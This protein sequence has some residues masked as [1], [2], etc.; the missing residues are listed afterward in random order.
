MKQEER[1]LLEDRLDVC[2]DRRRRREERNGTNYVFGQDDRR[3]VGC[4]CTERLTRPT[5]AFVMLV[6]W[7]ML[8]YR[9]WGQK[10]GMSVA[11]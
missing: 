9:R 11:G 6:T 7:D 1:R 5:G 4:R 10:I 3:A 8:M 2:R